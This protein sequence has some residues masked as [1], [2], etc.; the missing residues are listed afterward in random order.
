MKP[1]IHLYTAPV[2]KNTEMRD[3]EEVTLYGTGAGLYSYLNELARQLSIP[4]FDRK[5]FELKQ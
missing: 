3:P 1:E 5:P 2:E 4:D